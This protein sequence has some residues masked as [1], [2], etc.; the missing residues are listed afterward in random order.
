MVL[1]GFKGTFQTSA[2]AVLMPASGSQP[3]YGPGLGPPPEM[4][5]EGNSTNPFRIVR[6]IAATLL[7]LSAGTT[8]EAFSGTDE[9]VTRA[10]AAATRMQIEGDGQKRDPKGARDTLLSVSE[11]DPRIPLR[12]ALL[13]FQGEGTQRDPCQAIYW[14]Q[15]ARQSA[16]FRRLPAQWRDQGTAIV[17]EATSELS[18]HE[19]TLQATLSA[20]KRP[21]G[22]YRSAHPTSCSERARNL[23]GDEQPIRSDVFEEAL[24]L[25]GD[26]PEVRN[27]NASFLID[28]AIVSTAAACQSAVRVVNVKCLSHRVNRAFRE[29]GVTDRPAYV[30]AFLQSFLVL[31]IL[32]DSLD[33][34]E[35]DFEE[36]F[37]TLWTQFASQQERY[38][39][40]AF[41]LYALNKKLQTIER[42]QQRAN[43]RAARHDSARQA[44][45]WFELAASLSAPWSAAS[46]QGGS[47][48]EARGCTCACV[49]GA[50]VAVCKRTTAIPPSCGTKVCPIVPARV[51]P[52]DT[53]E[54]PPLGTRDCEWKQVALPN[55]SQYE[56][57]R[58]C[59]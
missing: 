49:D 53:V 27:L 6:S 50:H 16:S 51:P 32:V 46:A 5:W 8:H 40:L 47:D 54:L 57:R 58:V 9:A 10:L 21:I 7:A 23:A 4:T 48:L 29:N 13:A 43:A 45:A 31:A 2:P 24:R 12:L 44:Q 33:L 34:S 35:A 39:S 1:R 41:E 25:L 55:E 56:W 22:S 20:A 42:N 26:T 3:Y 37:E 15:I 59:R 38:D 36:S 52:V 18:G 14:A 30:R 19:A 11:L 17:Q 28:A